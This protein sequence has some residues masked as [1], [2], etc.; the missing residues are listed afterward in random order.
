[1]QELQVDILQGMVCRRGTC[2]WLFHLMQICACIVCCRSPTRTCRHISCKG[3]LSFL[4]SLRPL[5]D[6]MG[7]GKGRLFLCRLS[8]LRC[9]PG[10]IQMQLLQREQ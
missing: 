9:L 5:V 3:I 2:N 1:L 10:P 7:S 4:S 6:H 8:N